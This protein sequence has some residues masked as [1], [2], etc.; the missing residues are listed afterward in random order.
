MKEKVLKFVCLLCL[1][2]PRVSVAQIFTHSSSHR[3]AHM[4]SVSMRSTSSM[5]TGTSTNAVR[6]ERAY[7]YNASR[8]NNASCSA[9]AYKPVANV[10]GFYTAASNI[11]G[12]VTAAQMQSSA[13]K[14]GSRRAKMDDDPPSQPQDGSCDQCNWVWNEEIGFFVCTGCGCTDQVGCNCAKDGDYCHCPVGDGMDVLVLMFALAMTY[15]I[16]KVRKGEKKLPEC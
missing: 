9:S 10:Q 2:V 4:P 14:S 7:S 13:R 5:R 6:T 12:G 11:Y 8:S 1:F 15:G 3:S 16:L